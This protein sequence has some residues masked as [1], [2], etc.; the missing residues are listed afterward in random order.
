MQQSLEVTHDPLESCG[1]CGADI[2]PSS[3][4]PWH[5]EDDDCRAIRSPV[6]RRSPFDTIHAAEDRLR[7]YG[8][9]VLA[10]ELYAAGCLLG[11][12]LRR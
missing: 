5:T 3:T 6:T 8:E 4:F 10:D 9:N 2:G 7:L 11:S 1:S 12:S